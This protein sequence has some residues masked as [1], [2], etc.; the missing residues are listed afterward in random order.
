ELQLETSP[1]PPAEDSEVGKD[2][3]PTITQLQRRLQRL[4]LAAADGGGGAGGGSTVSQGKNGGDNLSLHVSSAARA[5]PPPPSNDGVPA[6]PAGRSRRRLSPASTE[7]T[8]SDPATVDQPKHGPTSHHRTTGNPPSAP[9]TGEL[10]DDAELTA[11][12]APITRQAASPLA[13][14]GIQPFAAW[15]ARASSKY[16]RVEKIA[17]GSYGEVF[18]LKLRGEQLAALRADASTAT[19]RLARRL[20]AYRDVIFKIVPLRARRGAGARSFTAVADLA[21]EVRLMKALDQVPGFARFREVHVLHGR[22]PP[23]YQAAWDAFARAR[24][25]Q[26]CNPDPRSRRSFPDAQL[27]AVLE[28]DD[29]GLEL[30]RELFAGGRITR[31]CEVY[32]VFWGVA[33]ALARAEAIFRFEHRDLHLGN[34]CIKRRGR[35]PGGD[36][37]R[38]RQTAVPTTGYGLS[39]IETSIIDFSLSRAELEDG[40]AE[41]KGGALNDTAWCNLDERGIFDAQGHD[42]DDELLRDTY[43]QCVFSL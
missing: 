3:R 15:A 9:P 10:I 38:P 35:D 4:D 27:W 37:A 30:E 20:A 36:T 16:Y 7:A 40:A 28:M 43:R 1:S 17:E 11:Y 23:A 29:A 5:S 12:V 33:M 39:G 22:Y 25:D 8:D 34:V 19:A 31:A 6:T 21:S 13:A 42:E 18:Q 41:E 26:C 24:P 14:A 2:S 32:D